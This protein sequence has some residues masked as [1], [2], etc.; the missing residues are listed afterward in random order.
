VRPQ[1]VAA[2]KV[3]SLQ[4]S[5]P[6]ACYE[7]RHVIRAVIP[8]NREADAY[9]ILDAE[10][11]A[12]MTISSIRCLQKYH[13]TFPKQL[14][15][16]IDGDLVCILPSFHPKLPLKS[17]FHHH[18]GISCLIIL[19]V[20]H[21]YHAHVEKKCDDCRVRVAPHGGSSNDP[22]YL[23]I[24]TGPLPGSMNVAVIPN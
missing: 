5:N 8:A 10:G 16:A 22:L 23:Y 2:N 20:P 6:R 9:V 18:Y 19:P 21:F 12:G 15:R 11:H 7:L 1:Q 14:L 13:R 3:V 24:A 4:G 17:R